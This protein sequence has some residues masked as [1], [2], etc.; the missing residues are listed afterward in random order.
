GGHRRW[1]GVRRFR[2]VL[3]GLL[4]RQKLKRQLRFSP[5]PRWRDVSRHDVPRPSRTLR[6]DGAWQDMGSVR[7]VDTRSTVTHIDPEYAST[8]VTHGSES[9]SHAWE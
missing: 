5:W 8:V 1:G 3:C 7:S 9:L 4:H 6:S 2:G